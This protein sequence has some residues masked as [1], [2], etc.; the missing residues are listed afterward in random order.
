MAKCRS[1]LSTRTPG[2]DFVL[3]VDYRDRT[4][5]IDF[6]DET[7]NIAT[8]AFFVLKP[9]GKTFKSSSVDALLS[10]RGFIDACSLRNCGDCIYVN[11]CK[12]TDRFDVGMLLHTS[13]G[14]R[15]FVVRFN[16]F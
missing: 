1:I 7:L 8:E 16:Q 3:V 10:Y 4:L 14:D 12:D 5:Q 13:D 2:K 9:D 6:G 11:Y 15:E